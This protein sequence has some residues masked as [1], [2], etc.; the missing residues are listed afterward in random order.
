M[1]ADGRGQRRLT[2]GITVVDY[3][4]NADGIHI[5]LTARPQKLPTDA[6]GQ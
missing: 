2:T 4:F 6:R 5:L 1:Q 3:T